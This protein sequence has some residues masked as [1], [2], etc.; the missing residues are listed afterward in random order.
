MEFE[1]TLKI[2]V[3]PDANFLETF[4]NNSDV[5]ME[6]VQASLYDIDD[7]I[8]EECEVRRDK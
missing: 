4:G 2:I 1:I 3:D 7:I 8:V 5:I 6:L